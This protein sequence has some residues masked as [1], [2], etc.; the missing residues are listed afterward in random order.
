MKQ[1]KDSKYIALKTDD[2]TRKKIEAER[3][4]Q[5]LIAYEKA[6]QSGLPEDEAEKAAEKAAENWALSVL[7]KLADKFG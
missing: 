2:A 3:D 7:K 4:T 1:D 6:R 5:M